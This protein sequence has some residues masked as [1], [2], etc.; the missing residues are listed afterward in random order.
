MPRRSSTLPERALCAASTVLLLAL[1]ALG[2]EA[3]AICAAPHSAPSLRPSGSLETTEPLTGWF[4]L[5]YLNQ[6]STQFY[7]SIGEQRR[8]LAEGAIEIR[9]VFLTGAFGVTE[10]LDVQAQLPVH[11]LESS[12]TAGS[13]EKFAFGDPRFAVRI[14]SDLFGLPR[15]P[16]MVRG[17]L[18][19]PGSRFP[20]DATIV[21]VTE[22]QV[23]WELGLET[24]Y[25]LS[26][27]R[28]LQLIAAAGYRWRGLND[29]TGRKPGDER[30]LYVG[31][32]GPQSGWRWGMTFEGVWGL[33]PTDNGIELPGARRKLLQLGPSV[34]LQLGRTEV[35]VGARL[36]MAGKNLANGTAFT[37][38]FYLPWALP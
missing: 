23:D 37:I 35:E 31:V 7:N 27:R 25:Y 17:G 33:T 20:V 21:P 19:L 18:K 24:G 26:G 8:F 16:V 15:M 29:A 30:F 14:G 4:Q 22:G 11:D 5:T 13:S 6:E 9:S 10:G 34:A 12:S 2:L 28:P 3:Q 38:G 36:P 1:G 32:G